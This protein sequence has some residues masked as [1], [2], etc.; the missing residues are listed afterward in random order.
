[1]ISDIVASDDDDATDAKMRS[2]KTKPLE[3]M[4]ADFNCLINVMKVLAI[5]DTCRL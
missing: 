1:M 5:V 2:T 3:T 4:K